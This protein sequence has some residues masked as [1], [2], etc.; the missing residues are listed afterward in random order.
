MGNQK[1]DYMNLW[2]SRRKQVLKN[3]RK[4]THTHME[5]DH[6]FGGP[7]ENNIYIYIICIYRMEQYHIFGGPIEPY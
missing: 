4:N 7:L 2:G 3:K 5:Q 1:E 6:I